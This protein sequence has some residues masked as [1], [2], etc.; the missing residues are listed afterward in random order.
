MVPVDIFIR[1][2]WAT[3]VNRFGGGC[4]SH[5]Q[6][7]C[8]VSYGSFIKDL[9][10]VGMWGITAEF[11]ESGRFNVLTGNHKKMSLRENIHILFLIKLLQEKSSIN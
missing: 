3:V 4:E 9:K 6:I 7:T 10:S 2:V 11:Y 5:T 1:K 8:F